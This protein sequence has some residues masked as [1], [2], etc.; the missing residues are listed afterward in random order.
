MSTT[1]I[2]G[3]FEQQSSAEA[4]IEEFIRAGF[5]P[6]RIAS[7]YVNPPGQHDA[8]PYGGDHEKSPGAKESDTGTALGA[9]AGGAVG[10]AA[11]PLLGPVGVVTGGLVGAHVGGLVGSMSK[12]KE[13]GDTGG[14]A[15]EE[16]NAVP[17]RHAGMMVA[18]AI[19]SHEQEDQ[20]INLLR[21]LGA[22]DVERAE[23]TIADGD[24]ID[25]DPVEP[26]VLVGLPPEQFSS[27]A[28]TQR[29]T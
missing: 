20:A 18:I 8:Y 9:A 5:A 28:T 29:H 14:N 13:H 19:D 10:V 6:E 26:P 2:A 27:D 3:R 15:E 1:I 16:E 21:S 23:G 17:L 22:A 25:F 7:F 24:W 4:T 12:M 11:A